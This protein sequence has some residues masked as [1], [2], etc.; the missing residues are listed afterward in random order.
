MHCEQ[1]LYSN[2]QTWDLKILVP[3]SVPLLLTL[4]IDIS[5]T[6]CHFHTVQVVAGFN[7][8]NLDLELIVLPSVLLLL[9]MDIDISATFCLFHS[10]RVETVFK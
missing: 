10:V 6:F 1:R 3:P 7:L 5:V 8:S 4:N 9:I 2:T